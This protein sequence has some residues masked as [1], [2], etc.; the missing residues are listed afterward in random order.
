MQR[1]SHQLAGQTGQLVAALRA[2]QVRD[3]WDEIQLER[4]VEL[5]GMTRH[6]DFRTQVSRTGLGED[7]RTVRPD[8][9]VRLTGGRHIVVD[10]AV[11]FAAYLYA[12]DPDVRAEQ[13]TRHAEHPRV[14]RPTAGQGVLG[15]LRPG[16]GIRGGSCPATRSSTPP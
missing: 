14:Y 5:A 15:R 7:D 6:C 1:T 12:R 11:P 8:L 10:A 9:V 4:M 3:R 2:P 13:L 16:A